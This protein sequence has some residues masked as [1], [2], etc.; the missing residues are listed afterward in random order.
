MW[1]RQDDPYLQTR[2][3]VQ[4]KGGNR[5]SSSVV[6]P[7]MGVSYHMRMHQRRKDIWQRSW[8]TWRKNLCQ[9]YF[10]HHKS[11]MTNQPVSKPLPESHTTLPKKCA[12]IY[13]ILYWF[14]DDESTAINLVPSDVG[15]SGLKAMQSLHSPKQRRKPRNF[16]TVHPVSRPRFDPDTSRVQ[17]PNAAFLSTIFCNAY[18]NTHKQQS[19]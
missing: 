17:V 13:N 18:V 16:P 12:H 14:N 1:I 10:V 3:Y 7:Q 15:L 11:R 5:P 19:V 8:N 9:C 4:L 2:R 6:R